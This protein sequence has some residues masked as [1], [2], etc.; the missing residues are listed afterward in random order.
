MSDQLNVISHRHES[1]PIYEEIEL[2][3]THLAFLHFS[4]R[5]F[6]T[7]WSLFDHFLV[8]FSSLIL[9]EYQKLYRREFDI[10]SIYNFLVSIW[11]LDWLDSYTIENIDRHRLVLIR[12]LRT[13]WMTWRQSPEIPSPD[14]IRNKFVS[15]G[16]IAMKETAE[17]LGVGLW[18]FQ[19]YY[20]VIL[21][22]TNL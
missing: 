16:V 22:A 19:G 4:G 11:F 6:S 20:S 9:S 1:W 7:S 12:D 18:T 8:T 17:G 3:W 14:K 2:K 13:V 10:L 5:S 15:W 21:Q